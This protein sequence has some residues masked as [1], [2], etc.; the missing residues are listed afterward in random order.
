MKTCRPGVPPRRVRLVATLGPATDAA[1]GIASLLE[2]GADVF[3]LNFSHGSRADHGRRLDAVREAGRRAG[4]SPAV[5]ADLQ[6]PKIRTGRTEGDLPVVL[7]QGAT[8]T[9]LAGAGGCDRRRIHIDWPPLPD[10]LRAGRLV[11]LNDGAV[12]LRVTRVNRRAGSARATVLNTGAYGSRKGVNLPGLDLP[13]PALTARDRADLRFAL[14]RGVDWVALSFV[15]RAADLEPVRRAVARAGRPV[16]I[17]A[18]IEK[19][20]AAERIGE[21]LE[22]CDGIMVARGDLGVE[23]S[24]E[25]VPILQKDLVAAARSR[26]RLAIVATQ[27][28]ESMIAAPSPTRAEATD[29]ANAILDGADAVM[30]SGETAVGAYPF[31]TVRVMDRIARRAEQSTYGVHALRELDFHPP[32]PT[33]ALCEAAAAASVDLG[34][35][36]ILVFTLSGA[37]AFLL[38]QVRCPAPVYAFTPDPAVAR[39]LSAAWNV[40]AFVLPAATTF[41]RVA[42]CA[43]EQLAAAGC[44]ARGDTVVVLTGTHPVRGATNL[45]RIKAVGEP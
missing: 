29:V 1:G 25:A 33:R 9:L 26:G 18:K 35:L 43:E 5:L 27:M 24:P 12:R 22:R 7:E 2:A 39:V 17:V 38:S 41:H 40:R 36:P 34:H 3:R 28:L 13:V 37:T 20:E 42:Q 6:G 8:V 30:L 32:G 10:H 44:V 19:P 4:R 11:L 31:E 16:R 21:L 45:L 14:A 15:R 23:T